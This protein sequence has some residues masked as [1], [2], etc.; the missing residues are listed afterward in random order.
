VTSVQ[1]ETGTADEP[2]GLT[3]AEA[4]REALAQEMRRDPSVF[5]LGED[6][7]LF[8]GPFGVTQ[9]L[10]D[11]FG[12]ERVRDTPVAEAGFFGLAVGAALAGMRPIVEVQYADFLPS[13]M[14]MIVNSAAKLR[15]MSGGVWGVP[16]VIRAPGGASSRGPTHGQSLES[17]FMNVPG[18]KVICPATPFDAKG[19]MIQAIR[20]DDPVICFEHRLLYGGH[21]PGGSMRSAWGEMR[22]LETPVP[23]S[24]YTLPFGQ[25]AVI[26]PGSQVTVAATLMMVHKSLRAADLLAAQGIDVEVIDL[27]TL[28]PL[29]RRTLIDSIARTRHLVVAVEGARTAGV[30]AEIAALAA[31]EAFEYLEAPVARVTSL[32][33]PVPLASPCEEFV[34]PQ[35]ADV[36]L[37]ILRTLGL[38]DPD[39]SPKGGRE[40]DR[41]LARMKSFD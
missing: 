17:W 9:G 37:A 19:L 33:C 4:I 2:R 8:G 31:E 32:D 30:A 23:Q 12:P 20:D 6:I 24:A 3:Y 38:A 39:E 14:D 5:V 16:M 25:A 26:R 13:A 28:V 1:H 11:E 22:S 18:L 21:S 40:R 10:V 35:E 41:A 15:M 27:R 7:G 29:D 34:L 36:R